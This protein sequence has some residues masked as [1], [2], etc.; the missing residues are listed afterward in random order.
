MQPYDDY[1]CP[2][3]CNMNHGCDRLSNMVVVL[4]HSCTFLVS[5]ALYV[6]GIWHILWT[7]M[8]RRGLRYNSNNMLMIMGWWYIILSFN[9]NFL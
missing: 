2:E 8:K 5:H 4:G 6:T 3:V 1:F 7:P 9:F